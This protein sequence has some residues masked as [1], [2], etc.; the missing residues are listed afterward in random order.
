MRMTEGNVDSRGDLVSADAL[1]IIP[2]NAKSGKDPKP[3]QLKQ[4]CVIILQL[5]DLQLPCPF[6]PRTT[7]CLYR[8]PIERKLMAHTQQ[9]KP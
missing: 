1:K 4:F 2:Y 6:I 7:K 5:S 8:C 9:Q 3:R